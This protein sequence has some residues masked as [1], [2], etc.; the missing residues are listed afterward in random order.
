MHTDTDTTQDPRTPAQNGLMSPPTPAPSPTPGRTAQAC[1]DAMSE[2]EAEKEEENVES[3]AAVRGGKGKG[4]R[5]D[6][7]KG[8]G[9]GKEVDSS[10][11]PVFDHAAFIAAFP[12]LPATTRLEIL[13][14]LLPVLS[15]PELLMLS[16]HIGPRL[17]RDFLRDLPIEL[18]LHILSFVDDPKTLA[19]A[20][21]V[22][23]YWHRLLEDEQ[24]WK[25]MCQRHRFQ[26]AG[27][28]SSSSQ[29]ASSS[30]SMVRAQYH[31]STVH[32]MGGH[33][34][35]PPLP[36]AALPPPPSSSQQMP[37]QSSMRTPQHMVVVPVAPGAGS[38]VRPR[39]VPQPAPI[40]G[41]TRLGPAQRA[42]AAMSLHLED[43]DGIVPSRSALE[44]LISGT[45][46]PTRNTN[47]NVDADMSQP[48]GTI[49]GSDNRLRPVFGV[50]NP[51]MFAA[52]RVG[53]DSGLMEVD[54][55]AAG[56]GLPAPAGIA[57]GQEEE[58]GFGRPPTG[59]TPPPPPPNTFHELVPGGEGT[60]LRARAP[61]SPVQ[62]D[63]AP[64]FAAAMQAAG[65]ITGDM[66]TAATTAA[67]AAVGEGN[68]F[69]DTTALDA[70]HAIPSVWDNQN[71]DNYHRQ[72][73]PLP[74]V[75]AAT[76][77]SAGSSAGTR[78]GMGSAQRVDVGGSEDDE[79][80][81]FSYKAH[82]KKSYLT[83]ASPFLL[84]VIAL[85]ADTLLCVVVTE[86]NWL[87]GGKLLSSHTSHD[88]GVVTSLAVDAEF[89]VIGMANSKIHIFSA[90]DG[91]F[92]KT[93]VGH[94][95]GV[96]CL[97]L[98]SPSTHEE[99]GRGVEG[100]ARRGGTTRRGEG[101]EDVGAYADDVMEV[102][103]GT[104]LKGSSA[105]SG[106]PSQWKKRRTR[107]DRHMSG[108][109]DHSGFS[110]N[111]S[112]GSSSG[113]G[114]GSGI[115]YMEEDDGE[116]H[117]PPPRARRMQQSDVCG[118]ARGWG[119]RDPIVISGGCDR[120]VKVWNVTTGQ[121]LHTLHGHT[122]T[123]RCMKT[124]N[125]R[126][127][128]V[129]GSRDASLRVW[130][131]ERGVLMHT[132]SGHQHSVRCIEV[133]GNQV[134][135]GSYDCTCRIWDLDTGECLQVLRGHY[136]QIYAVAFD[137]E[138]VATGSLDS[139][140]RIW[141]AATGECVAL[142]QGHTSLV[143]QLQLSND[144]LVTGGSDGR[145]IIFDL[146]DDRFIVSGG[147]DG[148]VKLWDVK[149][150]HFIRELSKPCE[151]VWRVTF[152]DDKCAILCKRHGK[153]V[154]EVLSFV[155]EDE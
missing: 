118:A 145:V 140:V 53:R 141:S 80:A 98:V 127:V 56:G 100:N 91:T 59:I 123:I 114:G 110:A 62:E 16:S 57:A 143:G 58:E 144:T 60:T 106:G 49:P 146:F 71:S 15:V 95:L 128:A 36:V 87:R 24:T 147:N 86:S 41:D 99:Q 101:E 9:K 116:A 69:D 68:P 151:A 40:A 21:A 23:R 102:E 11:D 50:T 67:A 52:S 129:S 55:V 121:C 10:N 19:R 29:G 136:H 51:Q 42:G 43:G 84:T 135:S 81:G 152:R 26:A 25:E 70:P 17:K 22:S 85:L 138:R 73:T 142:L 117:S 115:S 82:F 66:N 108:N 78:R 93:L 45:A 34:L 32:G 7:G 27:L 46:S 4:R 39:R 89:I 126:P 139:T 109:D 8:K 35:P 20:S 48:S 38:P 92:V 96:W 61:T 33:L 125:G 63:L 104:S 97:T 134:A 37:Q 153:T 122:S 72:Q 83:G 133:A 44:E 31:R 77:G 3:I 64:V 65:Q 103:Q 150:G 1:W 30:Q 18:A 2:D 119:Q 90:R 6:Q 88:D 14:S 113:G 28:G 107:D 94:E 47:I 112:Q 74:S 111:H 154:L 148:R 137:G 132:L 54:A 5:D 12:H 76:A 130:D 75:V 155:P 105:D 13:Q 131:V 120:D 149:T 124:I 79:P